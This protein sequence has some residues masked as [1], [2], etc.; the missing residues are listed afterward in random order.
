MKTNWE[1]Q[2]QHLSPL[3]SFPHQ[4][5]SPFMLQNHSVSSLSSSCS[6]PNL[7]VVQNNCLLAHTEEQSDWILRQTC[8]PGTAAEFGSSSSPN[9]IDSLDAISSW[10]M[11]QD[12]PILPQT[13]PA[14]ISHILLFLLFKIVYD[15]PAASGFHY[16]LFLHC[17]RKNEHVHLVEGFWYRGMVSSLKRKNGRVL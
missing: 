6:S 10:L 13:W 8:C 14:C 7:P 4:M 16:Q 5:P 2:L 15:A 12:L 17:I 11:Q 3:R 9:S 1:E